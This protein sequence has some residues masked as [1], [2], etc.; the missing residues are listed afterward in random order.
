MDQMTP[1][2]SWPR[3]NSVKLMRRQNNGKSGTWQDLR[4]LGKAERIQGTGTTVQQKV[5]LTRDMLKASKPLFL[6]HYEVDGFSK[7]KSQHPTLI[8]IPLELWILFRIRIWDRI[9]FFWHI[10]VRT[11]NP[12]L[13]YN[14]YQ[15]WAILIFKV[16]K[17]LQVKIK[18]KFLF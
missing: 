5:F 15:Y 9:R 10:P 17:P 18:H 4:F 11:E 6:T 8:S 7:M 3:T 12:Y 14:V 16:V 2:V 1:N 13:P